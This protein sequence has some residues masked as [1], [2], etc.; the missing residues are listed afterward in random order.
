[1]IDGDL[2]QI[3]PGLRKDELVAQIYHDAISGAGDD[4]GDCAAIMPLDVGT[5]SAQ[6]LFRVHHPFHWTRTAQL[7]P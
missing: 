5:R 7:N 6:G 3:E 4:W 1:M 2:E